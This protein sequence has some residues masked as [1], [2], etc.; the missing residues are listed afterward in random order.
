[1]IKIRLVEFVIL[2]NS[3]EMQGPIEARKVYR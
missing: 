2:L 1:M 3:V